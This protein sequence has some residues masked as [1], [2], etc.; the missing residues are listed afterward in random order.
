V[1]AC[2]GRKKEEV[3]LSELVEGGRLVKLSFVCGRESRSLAR[4]RKGALWGETA[5][6][7][8][9]LVRR[10]V[11]AGV[12]V[13]ASGCGSA[14]AEKTRADGRRASQRTKGKSLSFSLF[15]WVFVCVCVS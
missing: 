2:E 8:R 15:I 14:S 6:G 5:F 3:V 4:V 9:R 7:G 10:R 11:S 12:G 1:R 13:G